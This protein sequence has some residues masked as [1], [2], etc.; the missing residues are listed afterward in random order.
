[1]TAEQEGRQIAIMERLESRQGTLDEIILDHG[2]RLTTLETII[3]WTAKSI[4]GLGVLA[5]III[6]F[7]TFLSNN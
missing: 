6:S 7:L 3:K 4:A 2:T 5:L 1:M